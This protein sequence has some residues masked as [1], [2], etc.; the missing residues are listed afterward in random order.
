MP[1]SYP[2]SPSLTSVSNMYSQ[3]ANT[4]MLHPTWQQ[5]NTSFVMPPGYNYQ[6]SQL[7]Q[8][9]YADMS[10]ATMAPPPMLYD[11]NPTP[12]NYEQSYAHV[13]P[14]HRTR[15]LLPVPVAALPPSPIS[16]SPRS[17]R[18]HPPSPQAHTPSPMGSPSAVNMQV[19]TNY[20]Y[21]PLPPAP[22][23]VATS[24]PSPPP[25]VPHIL[26]HPQPATQRW[27]IPQTLEA[28]HS[29]SKVEFRRNGVIG[30]RVQ[31]AI[32]NFVEIDAG[33]DRVLARIGARTIRL[34]LHV[35]DSTTLFMCKLVSL[36]PFPYSVAGVPACRV[37][38]DCQR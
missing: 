5:Y 34:A 32:R 8:Y 14:T 31:D 13:P 22:T 38:R 2:V 9:S 27:R 12:H 37:L 11:T 33:E 21:S 23:Q 36:T 3:Q 17:P 20:S 26:P 19:Y 6:H 4:D 25:H 29:N 16:R 15:P 7:Q 18:S 30:I 1:H 35:S 10:P 24:P 28:G